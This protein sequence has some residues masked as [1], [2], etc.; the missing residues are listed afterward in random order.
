MSPRGAPAL[1]NTVGAYG[2][3]P[4]QNRLAGFTLVTSPQELVSYTRARW[5]KI[6][7]FDVRGD[8]RTADAV[9]RGLKLIQD[10][11]SLGAVESTIERIASVPGQEHLPPM[12]L[13]L[14]VGIEGIEDRRGQ[15][16]RAS[17]Q[18]ASQICCYLAGSYTKTM[19]E[20]CLIVG[21]P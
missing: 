19:N 18:H 15:S 21:Q 3:G 8:A 5:G 11:T 4:R 6:I 10:A 2:E 16:M 13:W 9:M 1:F 12:L 20:P 14:S 17:V 7:S